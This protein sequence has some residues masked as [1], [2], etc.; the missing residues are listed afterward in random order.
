MDETNHLKSIIYAVA[1][2]IGHCIYD[3][4]LTAPDS[5]GLRRCMESLNKAYVRSEIP[6]AH[7]SLKGV[8][9]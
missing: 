9:Y 5:G 1:D 2:D 6:H 7:E 3:L 8:P 4:H